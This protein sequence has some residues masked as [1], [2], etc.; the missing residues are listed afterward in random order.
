MTK[1][2]QNFESW[3]YVVDPNARG[4]EG[5]TYSADEKHCNI[6]HPD[7]VNPNMPINTFTVTRNPRILKIPRVFN[8][9]DFFDARPRDQ[10][11]RVRDQIVSYWTLVENRDLRDLKQIVY[12]GVIERNLR[13]YMEEV[14][15]MK[16]VHQWNEFTIQASD[17]D[18]AYQ[19]LLTRTPFLAGAQKM[20][21]EYADKFAGKKIQSCTFEPLGGFALFDFI[22]TLT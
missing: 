11:L 17:T 5:V 6:F 14:Y 1:S 18:A 8:D 16:E 19:L 20:L 3:G 7:A 15:E 21:T 9:S 2:I 12:T 4:F 13:E 10:K 22:I